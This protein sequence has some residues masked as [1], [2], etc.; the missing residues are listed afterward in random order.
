M[1]PKFPRIYTTTDACREADRS[2]KVLR[3]WLDAHPELIA[4]RCTAGLIIDADAFDEFMARKR[5]APRWQA[6]E[7]R[8]KRKPR[9][10]PAPAVSE[11]GHGSD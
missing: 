7:E 3:E 8:R 6:D 5:A 1:K 9:P 11:V 2:R 4:Y 10:T